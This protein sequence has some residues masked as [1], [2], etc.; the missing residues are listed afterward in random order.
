MDALKNLKALKDKLKQEKQ[1][2]V[3]ADKKAFSKGELEAARLLKLRQE[4][5]EE[6]KRK[7]GGPACSGWVGR[8]VSASTCTRLHP[9]PAQHMLT[10]N[11]CRSSSESKSRARLTKQQPASK[12]ARTSTTM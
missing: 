1:D 10:A 6:R 8:M 9:H 7:V 5:E 2:L 4:E 12:P 11:L 3:G